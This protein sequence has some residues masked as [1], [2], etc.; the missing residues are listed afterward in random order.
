MACV[1]VC[2]LDGQVLREL[3]SRAATTRREK[4]SSSV[5]V[6]HLLRI[7][8]LVENSIADSTRFPS[9]LFSTDHFPVLFNINRLILLYFPTDINNFS[10]WNGTTENYGFL[11][12]QPLT[13]T[14]RRNFHAFTRQG[15][16]LPIFI[17]DAASGFN[18]F[19]SRALSISPLVS[20]R[21]CGCR[22]LPLATRG[23]AAAPSR[24]KAPPLQPLHPPPPRQPRPFP[25]TAAALRS[26]SVI[27]SRHFLCSASTHSISSLDM[28][29]RSMRARHIGMGERYLKLRYGRV[30]QSYFVFADSAT[31]SASMRMPK[32]RE[33][34][35]EAR[36]V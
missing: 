16:D 4:R 22:S 36:L 20:D 10:M 17:K 14:V 12:Q 35:V 25:L 18:T 33:G 11:L 19:A 31:R 2:G 9:E 7:H 34:L 8:L 1:R 32:P 6:S 29:S 21:A 28:I 24:P 15:T 3:T 13:R 5:V 23:P 30:P 26:S 27:S